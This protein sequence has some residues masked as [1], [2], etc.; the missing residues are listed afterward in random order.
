M[1]ADFENVL[2]W[3]NDEE[4]SPVMFA[5]RDREVTDEER[6]V[7]ASITIEQAKKLHAYL[8]QLLEERA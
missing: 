8:T 2:F 7:I 6:W 3:V 1:N 5:C 4:N